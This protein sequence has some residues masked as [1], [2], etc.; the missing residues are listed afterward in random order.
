MV[1]YQRPK[2]S[3]LTPAWPKDVSSPPSGRKRKTEDEVPLKPVQPNATGLPS[4]CRARSV[5]A[6]SPPDGALTTT[7]PN[8]PKVGSRSPGAA[9]AGAAA[10]PPS[11]QSTTA[12]RHE[13]LAVLF[14]SP[15]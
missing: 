14:T 15:P 2:S 9:D 1:W 10:P 6:A 3:E 11:T 7:L 12:T 13:I 5:A 4:G 8:S